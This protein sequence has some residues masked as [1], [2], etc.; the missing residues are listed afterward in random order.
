MRDEAIVACIAD[1]IAQGKNIF[2]AYGATHAVMQRA[3]LES[4]WQD[5]KKS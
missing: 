4:I 3:A 5:H 2:I 1:L